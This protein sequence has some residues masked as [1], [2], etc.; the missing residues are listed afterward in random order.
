MQYLSTKDSKCTNFCVVYR[1]I[2]ESG[3]LKG[4]PRLKGDFFPSSPPSIWV[5][6]WLDEEIVEHNA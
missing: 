4:G 6:G 5:L 3:M 2:G 1:Y